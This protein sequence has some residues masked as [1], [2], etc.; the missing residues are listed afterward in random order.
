MAK[1]PEAK[2]KDWLRKELNKEFPNIWIYMAPGGK[3][4]RKGVPDLLC[5]IDG[6]FVAIE[7]KAEEGMEGT[8]SQKYEIGLLKQSKAIAFVMDGKNVLKLRTLIKLIYSKIN[9]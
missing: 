1:G 9:S 4:G 5:S 2:V 3:F 8:P 7:V 6:F